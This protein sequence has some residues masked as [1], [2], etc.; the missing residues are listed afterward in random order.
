MVI[1]LE[2]DIC[3]VLWSLNILQIQDITVLHR[4]ICLAYSAKEKTFSEQALITHFYIYRYVVIYIVMSK[5]ESN[6][7]CEAAGSSCVTCAYSVM[8]WIGDFMSSFELTM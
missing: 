6:V 7:M 5:D 4:T 1:L 2:D 8:F 3:P